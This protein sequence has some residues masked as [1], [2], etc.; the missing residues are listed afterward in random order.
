MDFEEF[1][2]TLCIDE[3]RFEEL[4]RQVT[5][6]MN[7]HIGV[8]WPIIMKNVMDKHCD[9][10]VEFFVAGMIIGM[11]IQQEK[12]AECGDGLGDEVIADPSL[13]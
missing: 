8:E 13:I 1:C 7:Q 9:A 2:K 3:E 5:D 6:S 10:P 4:S 12:C 11:Q